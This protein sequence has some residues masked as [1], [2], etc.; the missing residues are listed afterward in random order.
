[1]QDVITSNP[2]N[3]AHVC[4]VG[5][6][7]RLFAVLESNSGEVSAKARVKIISLL[8]IFRKDLSVV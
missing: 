6:I 5:G 8:E 7:D 3:V 1:M 2:L 4:V